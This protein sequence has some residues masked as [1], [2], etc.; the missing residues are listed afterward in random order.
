MDLLARET[1]GAECGRPLDVLPDHGPECHGRDRLTVA[2]VAT[3]ARDTSPEARAAI[4]VKFGRQFDELVASPDRELAHAVLGLLTRDVARVVRQA[5]AETIAG[6]LSLPAA[7]AIAMARDEIEIAWPVLER[8]PVLE[9]E[10]L[11]E[12]VRT[13]SMRYALAVAGRERV[14]AAVVHV[15]VDT[16]HGAVVARVV[17]NDGTDL[18]RRTLERVLQEYRGDLD[19]EA[20]LIHRPELPPEIVEQLV[21]ILSARVEA[22][23]CER[24][25][26]PPGLAR[27]IVRAMGDRASLTL[28]APERA[29]IRTMKRLRERFDAGALGHDELLRWL[30]DGDAGG[31]ELGLALHAGLEPAQVRRLLYSIDR[32]HLAALCIAAGLSTPHYIALRTDLELA[33]EAVGGATP[34]PCSTET[35]CYLQAQYER[36]ARD[37]AKLRELLAA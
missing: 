4:A 3:L 23:L 6:S 34:L 24:H 29:E 14:S 26:Q 1:E 13:S 25:G 30:R 10:A 16:G 12:I 7:A 11:V 20:R 19:V 9:D 33:E 17:G 27:S 15:L 21:G 35:V 22:S 32:R 31:V 28:T 5:L 8:S 37:D 2:D 18:S 36:L